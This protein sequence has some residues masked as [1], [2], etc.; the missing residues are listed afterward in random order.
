MPADP[1]EV[2]PCEAVPLVAAVPRPAAVVPD[3]AVAP[4]VP[5]APLLLLAC[6]TTGLN[7]TSEM[8]PLNSRGPI[9]S[10][11]NVT[12]APRSYFASLGLSHF[13]E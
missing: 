2:L 9:D 3:V 10:I 13:R 7:R 1:V 6:V 5:V 4:A 11:L 12:G 8:A